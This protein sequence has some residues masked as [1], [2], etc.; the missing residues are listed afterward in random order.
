MAAPRAKVEANDYELPDDQMYGSV[1]HAQKQAQQGAKKPVVVVAAAG[2][3]V[4][5]ASWASITLTHAHTP[6]STRIWPLLW[7][8]VPCF[9]FSHPPNSQHV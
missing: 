3:H 8:D 4:A 9:R 2:E 5:V 1:L 7:G 6:I